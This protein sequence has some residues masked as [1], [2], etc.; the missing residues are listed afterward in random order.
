MAGDPANGL[1]LRAAAETHP[2]LQREHNEDTFLCD[3][4]HGIFAV[5][6]GVGGEAAGEAAAYKAAEVIAARLKRPTGSPE[7]RLREAITLANNAIFELARDDYSRHGMSCVLT[8][9]LL[10]GERLTIGHVGDTRLYRLVG[11]TITKLT[12]DHSTVGVMEE[13][14][15]LSE[16]E[17]MAH[18]LRNEILR[19]VG[20]EPMDLDS[21]TF[22]DVIETRFRPDEALLICSDGL[23]DLVSTAEIRAVVQRF[24]GRPEEAVEQLIATA[25]EAGGRDNITA[26]LVEGERFASQAEE[27][28]PTPPRSAQP[29]VQPRWPDEPT[30]RRHDLDPAVASL[31]PPSPQPPAPHGQG[32]AASVR[33]RRPTR[34]FFLG[35]VGLALVILVA[36]WRDDLL[37]RLWPANGSDGVLYVGGSR[38]SYD[39]IGQ[40]LAAARPG[41]TVEVA[42][43]IYYEQ[44]ELADGVTVI[45]AVPRGAILKLLQEA[46]A[47]APIAVTANGVENAALVGFRIVGEEEHPLDVGIRLVDSTVIL[48]DMLVAGA[49]YVGIE[50]DGAGRTVVRRST[51]SDNGGPGI[52]LRGGATRML[53]CLVLRNGQGTDPPAAGIEIDPGA[54]VLM[55]GNR[56]ADNAGGPIRGLTAESYDE[57]RLR[58]RFD[59]TPLARP[60]PA[61]T[62]DIGD[63]D[64]GRDPEGSEGS[65][66]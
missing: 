6:D 11:G 2:G 18:P 44:I 26:V 27:Q 30:E 13:K 4:K 55:H 62:G 51:V 16:Q 1:Q 57:V 40:A 35:L 5:I 29:P 12:R 63:G 49:S 59:S 24:A 38:G 42:E 60:A 32:M 64:S 28:S 9:A 31:A 22:I 8:V 25:N 14:G 39:S 37:H 46:G 10:E 19:D 17:A 3:E 33:E 36:L 41:Q 66:P 15:E 21:E 50:L 61:Q 45:S 43:G 65:A 47:G 52:H 34:V 54:Y 58:N 23:T 7:R 20:S 56:L 53:D 48:E